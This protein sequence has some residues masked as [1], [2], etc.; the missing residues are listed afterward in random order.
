MYTGVNSLNLDEKGRF[1]I[2]AKYREAL[3]SSCG[4]DMVVTVNPFDTCLLVYPK[5]EWE[6]VLADL[7]AMR[8]T[9][10][11]IS[12]TQRLMLG[13]AHDYQM[14]AQGR[15]QIPAKLRDL[16]GLDRQIALV[17]QANKFELWDESR[18][19]QMTLDWLQD[20]RETD[21]DSTDVFDSLSL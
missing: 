2:P 5:P 15:I 11:K 10:S 17:G 12:R 19:D 20:G 21:D 6:R 16:A 8:N 9:K 7:T 3:L 14:T 13:Y 1:A 4:G 18:W